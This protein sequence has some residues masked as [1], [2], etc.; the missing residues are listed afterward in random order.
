MM[1]MNS[2]QYVHCCC[3]AATRLCLRRYSHNT[4]VLHSTA[5]ACIC[6]FCIGT[7]SVKARSSNN[8]LLHQPILIHLARKEKVTKGGS[9]K[10]AGAALN[11]TTACQP[12]G[13]LVRKVGGWRQQMVFDSDIW[14]KKDLGNGSGL[15]H[16][17]V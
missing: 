12:I 10:V 15:P 1:Q 16:F 17:D 3:Y 6:W 4:N 8:L 14:L 2:Y 9:Y 5:R 7:A 13:L 11:R